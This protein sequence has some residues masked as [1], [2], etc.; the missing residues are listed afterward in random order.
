MRT[1]GECYIAIKVK[2][3]SSVENEMGTILSSP[4]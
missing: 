1:I 4:C 3:I 2:Y